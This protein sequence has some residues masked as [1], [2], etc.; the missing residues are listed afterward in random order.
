MVMDGTVVV[1]CVG[2]VLQLFLLE[3][4]GASY[5]VELKGLINSSY[6]AYDWF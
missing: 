3:W 5:I 1:N 6:W 4:V 2:N